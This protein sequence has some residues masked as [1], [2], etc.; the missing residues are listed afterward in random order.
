MMGKREGRVRAGKKGHVKGG[1]AE[2][3]S[4]CHWLLP[5]A[6]CKNGR[7]L[8]PQ[9]TFLRLPGC[10]PPPIQ[11]GGTSFADRKYHCGNGQTNQ[12]W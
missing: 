7:P 4:P 2:E 12:E 9:I 3:E 5:L 11:H 8:A 10:H 1:A 6:R